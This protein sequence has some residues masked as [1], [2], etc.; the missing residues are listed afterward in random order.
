MSEKQQHMLT[1][2]GNGHWFVIPADKEEEFQNYLAVVYHFWGS[3]PEYHEKMVHR[4]PPTQPDWAVKVG[5]A[6]SL[7]KFTD[8]EIE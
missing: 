6:P 5:G 7:V 2:D 8:Y 3:L 4:L 1:Q